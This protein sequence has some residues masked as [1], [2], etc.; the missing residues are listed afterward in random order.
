MMCCKMSSYRNK[1]SAVV[2]FNISI[3]AAEDKSYKSGSPTVAVV[4]VILR[5][6]DRL[7]SRAQQL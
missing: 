4:V 3:S 7:H 5:P 6:S 1:I 2:S